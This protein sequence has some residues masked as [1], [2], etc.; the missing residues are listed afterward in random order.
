LRDPPA[1]FEF[2]GEMSEI[3]KHL[4][5]DRTHVMSHDTAEED[6]SES[7]RGIAG[8]FALSERHAAGRRMGP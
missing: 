2:A 5:V 4:W 6:A 3:G 8:K 7:R 1:I